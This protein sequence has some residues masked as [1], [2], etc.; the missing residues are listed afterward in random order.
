MQELRNHS[1]AS[2]LRVYGT[3]PRKTH[4]ATP[5]AHTSQAG[6][7]GACCSQ[8]V[9]SGGG[10]LHALGDP[11]MGYFIAPPKSPNLSTGCRSEPLKTKQFSTL[12]SVR[13]M[14][15]ILGGLFKPLNSHRDGQFQLR[16]KHEQ[17]SEGQSQTVSAAV[18]CD[19]FSPGK[20]LPPV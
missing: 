7:N 17:P 5:A 10:K 16:D 1:L 8:R 9:T 15:L 4:T 6:V 20:T 18:A 14:S 19:D 12:M 11:T 3:A 13:K 2:S